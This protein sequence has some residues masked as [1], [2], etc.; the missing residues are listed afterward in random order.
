MRLRAQQGASGCSA[1]VGLIGVMHVGC[2]TPLNRLCS[3]SLS[4]AP[5]SPRSEAASFG[6][7]QSDRDRGQ[8][9]RAGG[10]APV[11]A[12]AVAAAAPPPLR[13][14][15]VAPRP[16][17]RPFARSS[18]PSLN[19]TTPNNK[20]NSDARDIQV[21]DTAE[22]PEGFS[23][24]KGAATTKSFKKLEAGA[25]ASFSY[26]VIPGKGGR[27]YVLPRASVKYTVY[28]GNKDAARKA[29][30]SAPMLYV[31]TPA[32][33]AFRHVLTA[34]QYATLGVVRTPEQWRSLAIIGG[35]VGFVFGGSTVWGKAKA[36]GAAQRRS[37]ALA[38]LE[39]E[40]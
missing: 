19:T 12:A 1:R 31:E 38:A 11:R 39:K 28:E 7:S 26:S 25:T 37:K 34:G 3:L 15:T 22:L 40:K 23:L 32:E 17:S 27:A 30:S 16:K 20:N 14:V 35:F 5:P 6:Q 9:E 36:A 13:A 18:P 21:D 8:A 33:A 29:L 10:G 2:T 24:A 4:R